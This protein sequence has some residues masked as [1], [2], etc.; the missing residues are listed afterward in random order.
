[1]F[2]KHSIRSSTT[3]S[4]QRA[5]V[6]GVSFCLCVFSNTDESLT[7][8]LPPLGPISARTVITMDETSLA[9]VGPWT[10]QTL[11]PSGTAIRGNEEELLAW[12]FI[13][14]R[15]HLEELLSADD[16]CH[17]KVPL[18]M[19]SLL[20]GGPKGMTPFLYQ[21]NH[22]RCDVNMR[23]SILWYRCFSR[24]NESRLFSAEKWSWFHLHLWPCAKLKVNTPRHWAL[25]QVCVSDL[26]AKDTDACCLLTESRELIPN[27]SLWEDAHFRISEAYATCRQASDN[28]IFEL[29][30]LAAHR[31]RRYR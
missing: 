17:L 28:F 8:H 23:S 1:M 25:N 14:E 11:E 26:P 4:G 2:S 9:G 24:S 13:P 3:S 30:G 29:G 27:A 7:P 16:S 6:R 12:E 10:P 31:P 15:A 5:G 18:P 22:R 20:E 19:A 21:R